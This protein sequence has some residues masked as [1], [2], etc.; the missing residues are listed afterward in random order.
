MPSQ[1]FAN[2]I[3]AL[4]DG[5]I[6]WDDGAATIKAILVKD[7]YVHSDTNADTFDFLDDVVANRATGTTD[8]TIGSRTIVKDATGNEVELKG[9]ATVTFPT[10]SSGQNVKG[11]IVYRDVGGLDSTR[12]LLSYNEFA[13]VLAGN[14]SDIQVTFAAEGIAKFS[15]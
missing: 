7:T 5:S 13:S 14:G 9:P 3:V 12:R 8:Q 6:D 1:L 11:I 2:G 15:Y 4:V 10:V